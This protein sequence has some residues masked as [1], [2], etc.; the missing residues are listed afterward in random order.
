[1][2]PDCWCTSCSRPP[3]SGTC[4]GCAAPEITRHPYR[5]VSRRRSP[6][7]STTGGGNVADAHRPRFE[8]GKAPMKQDTVIPDSADVVI[9]GSGAAGMTAAI[10]AARHG[11]SAVVVEKAGRWGGSTARSGGGVWIPGNPVLRREAPADDIDAARAYLTAI[12]GDGVAPEMIDTYIDRGAEAFEF[13][14]RH[15]PLA[16]RWVPGY[17]DYYPEAPGGRSHG[18]SV[19]PEPFDAR[20]LGADL[21]TMEP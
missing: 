18:R 21:A 8:A 1:A 14:A 17:S 12:I 13:L 2:A 19:E 11:L 7:S 10:T 3:S 4:S 5:S 16:M 20:T 15:A 9:V 6:R